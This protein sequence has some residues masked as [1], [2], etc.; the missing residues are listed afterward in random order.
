M[1]DVCGAADRRPGWPIIQPVRQACIG[2][3]HAVVEIVHVGHVDDGRFGRENRSP[4]VHNHQ[5]CSSPCFPNS[6]E[7][8]RKNSWCCPFAWIPPRW[9]T[10]EDRSD[11]HTARS[12]QCRSRSSMFRRSMQQRESDNGYSRHYHP[13]LA[14]RNRKSRTR[15]GS[16]SRCANPWPWLLYTQGPRARSPGRPRRVQ[17]IGFPAVSKLGLCTTHEGRCA[18]QRTWGE[19]NPVSL[20]HGSFLVDHGEA[21][22]IPSNDE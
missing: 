13:W 7:T 18:G 22:D 12:L 5:G 17:V 21:P 6:L 15:L 11:G 10:Q 2:R 1:I 4:T 9:N 20:A 3:L 16:R 8:S 19:Q 14:S